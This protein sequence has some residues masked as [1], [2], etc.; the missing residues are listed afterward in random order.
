MGKRVMSKMALIVLLAMLVAA[1]PTRL[2]AGPDDAGSEQVKQQVLEVENH[3][4][5]A[6]LHADV[7][8]LDQIY[9]D[10]LAYMNAGGEV[11]S[12]AEVLAKFKSGEIKLMTLG[13]GDIRLTLFG[14]AVILNG[15]STAA[16]EYKGHVSYGPRRFTNV[17]VKVDGAWRLASHNVSV[18]AKK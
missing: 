12:K 5:Q 16:L 2:L 17:Y 18:M 11:M 7:A 14:D 6:M 13:R 3:L 10:N 15:I 8:T 4:N 9:T 1:V